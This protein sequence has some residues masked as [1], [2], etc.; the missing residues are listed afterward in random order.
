MSNGN[1][2]NSSA[3]SVRLVQR[4]L[5]VRCDQRNSSRVVNAS[6]HRNRDHNRNLVRSDLKKRHTRSN[7][8]NRKN[9]N[10]RG[11]LEEVDHLHKAA[12]VRAKVRNRN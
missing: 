6:Q 3:L 7:S 12:A 2:R 11:N 1:A 9:K 5:S 8:R 4:K 10:G